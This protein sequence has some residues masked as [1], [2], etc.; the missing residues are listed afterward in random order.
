MKPTKNSFCFHS[1]QC[2]SKVVLSFL[3]L[4]C[5]TIPLACI[6]HVSFHYFAFM[7]SKIWNALA[8][9]GHRLLLALFSTADF[10][11]SHATR[12][13]GA[14]VQFVSLPLSDTIGM[15][16]YRL[17]LVSLESWCLSIMGRLPQSVKDVDAEFCFASLLLVLREF[18]GYPFRPIA[19]LLA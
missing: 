2:T 19:P 15:L 6:S 9:S 3:S 11:S 5:S 12:V 13:F 14:L 10:R 8:E 1:K 7:V 16:R 17:L 4:N 18:F